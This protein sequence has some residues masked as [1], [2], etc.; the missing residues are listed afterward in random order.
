M[1]KRAAVGLPR[2]LAAAL[3]AAACSDAVAPER[4]GGVGAPL[5]DVAASESGSGSLGQSGTTLTIAFSP[6]NPHRGD[7]VIVSFFWLGSTN[8]ITAVTDHL[9]NGAPVGNTYTLVEYVTGGG[10]S[11][12]TYVATNVQNF[13]DPNPDASTRLLVQA[14]LSSTVSDGG[15][16]ISAYAGVSAASADALGAHR[17]AS[18]SSSTTT[19]AAPGAIAVGAGALTY[20]V[21]MSNGLAGLG[22][23]TGYTNIAT[24]SDAALKA[25]GE[26]A[27][28]ATAGSA[29]PQ[30]TWYFDSPGSPRTWLAT[31]V[32]LNS[33]GG[34]GG[35]PPPPPPP[36]P[37]APPPPPAPPPGPAAGGG[38][39]GGL[40]RR[41]PRGSRS[42]SSRAAPPP[43]A[44]S[45]R[46]CR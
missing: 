8:I 37:R 26:Y 34:G 40:R 17:S 21:T 18:G 36:P 45:R 27:A 32:A 30:W 35:A 13:P 20:A 5:L 28:Q 9:A 3:L 19:T 22:R 39:G 25:G 10:I 33:A 46:R 31:V 15:V 7:A 38:G 24:M 11:M 44:R 41:P 14:A 12:A 42:R 16:M 23:P 1:H 4:R 6:T 43:E 29:D 2:I